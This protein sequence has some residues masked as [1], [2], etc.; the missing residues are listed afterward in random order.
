MSAGGT[1][2]L[3]MLAAI[4]DRYQIPVE[5]MAAVPVQGAANEV[6]YLG[7]HLVLRIPRGGGA[8]L[9]ELAKEATIIPAVR[10][11]GVRTPAVVTYDD[12]CSVVNVPYLVVERV[13]G[14]DLAALGAEPHTAA[15]TYRDVG[16]GLARL[17]RLTRAR[18]GS[19]PG[20]AQLPEDDPRGQV[21]RLVEKGYVDVD[22]A[23][24]LAGW[25]DRLEPLR[26]ADV[27]PAVVH[28]DVSP[29]NV[30]VAGAA[31]ERANLVDWGDA[32]W[33]D[34]AVD[35]AKLPLRAVPYALRGYLDEVP[36]RVLAEAERAWSGRVLWYHLSW[37]LHR[38]G[39]VP[40]EPERVWT[41]P[42]ASRLLEL[43]RFFA[44]SPPAP[45][46]DLA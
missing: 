33:A 44:G 4:G 13:P 21:L 19:L 9:A 43:L 2:R 32:A 8:R 29:T 15:A 26:P 5:D 3:E 7:D 34:P 38:V 35:F 18:V 1:S 25:F 39:D 24:W 12:S 41:R 14:R 40:G 23:G 30:V 22:T 46:P 17:H 37:A 6:Y 45:W 31:P 16:V 27:A 20:V 42:P 10:R 11:V 36:P 28:G